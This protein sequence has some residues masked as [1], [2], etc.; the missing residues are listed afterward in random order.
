MIYAK[1]LI[2][3]CIICL[4]ACKTKVSHYV[5]N[6]EDYSSQHSHT[7]KNGIISS[8]DKIDSTMKSNQL[9]FKNWLTDSLKILDTS[10]I[11]FNHKYKDIHKGLL[12]TQDSLG[13]SIISTFDLDLNSNHYLQN[14]DVNELL[15]TLRENDE[16][17]K[18][19]FTLKFKVNYFFTTSP[20]PDLNY[21]LTIDY[22]DIQI[23]ENNGK[24]ITKYNIVRGRISNKH[25]FIFLE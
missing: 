12:I 6:L 8:N 16:Y 10:I 9:K 11:N 5:G 22:S 3:F 13:I 19:K 24:K 2:A 4:V 17:P 14:V 20:V 18:G 15:S 1:Q 25:V 7:L 23:I 21:D